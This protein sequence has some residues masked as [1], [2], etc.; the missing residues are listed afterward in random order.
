MLWRL[1]MH[2]SRR[3]SEHMTEAPH[4]IAPDATL[5]AAQQLMRE[6]SLSQLPVAAEGTSHG[7]LLERDLLLARQLGVNFETALVRSL[8]AHDAFSVTPDESLASAVRAMASRAA[9]CAVVMEGTVVRGVLTAAAA[10][11]VL[12]EH[13]E[14]EQ[15]QRAREATSCSALDEGCLLDQAEERAQRLLSATPDTHVDQSLHELRSVV[16]EL[17]EE[18]MARVEAEE[19]ELVC[20]PDTTL[21]KNRIA[22]THGI[23]KQQ[24]QLLEGVLMGLDDLQQ[25]V[26]ALAASVQRAVESLRAD[27]EHDREPLRFMS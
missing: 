20:A 26:T 10:L 3:V 2:A 17:Y 24:A 21:R 5:S 11:R 7:V 9:I 1:A 13:L 14:A 18:R 22:Q 27:L 19:R 6:R 4:A 25:P 8:I 12:A 16:R 23:H 15:A